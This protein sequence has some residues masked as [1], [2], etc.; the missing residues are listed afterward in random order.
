MSGRPVTV[1][2]FK[3]PTTPHWRLE[4]TWLGE[5]SH[6]VWLGAPA[7]STIQKGTEPPRAAERT[8]AQLI[9]PGAWWTAM[10]NTPPDPVEVYVDITTAPV[11]P[12]PDRVE[13]IDLDLDV[14]RLADGTVYV[15]DEDEFIEHRA[16]LGYPP[17]MADTARGTAARL[18]M[19]L[20]SRHPPF[21]TE[22]HRWLAQVV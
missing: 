15:D 1:Q 7:G 16:T 6:G 19:D 10:F 22:W 12:Q 4:T 9:V 13:M 11:W 18:V 8:F 5:D 17:L 2:Y 20:E 3:Y 14:V 21:D